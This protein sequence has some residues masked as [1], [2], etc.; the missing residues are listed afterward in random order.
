MSRIRL[1][2]CSISSLINTLHN[3]ASPQRVT[4]YESHKAF[5][6]SYK[7]TLSQFVEVRFFSLVR[8]APHKHMSGEKRLKIHRTMVLVYL[9][10]SVLMNYPS[11]AC[12]QPGENYY[13]E[14]QYC[15]Y[16]YLDI[17]PLSSE[18]SGVPKSINFDMPVWKVRSE[19]TA[20]C[21]WWTE[22]SARQKDKRCDLY[23]SSSSFNSSGSSKWR[24][25]TF[26]PS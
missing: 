24:G 5:L 12:S 13:Q 1:R 11:S 19:T 4:L 14:S 17:L 15:A 10:F 3:D 20:F 9:P 26:S 22:G 7:M 8:F 16:A 25:L 2:F 23:A 21:R 6:F 18:E